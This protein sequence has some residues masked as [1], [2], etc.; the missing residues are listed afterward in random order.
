MAV[1]ISSSNAYGPYIALTNNLATY[2]RT[3]ELR[4]S[5]TSDTTAG[6]FE[7]INRSAP[8]VRMTVSELGAIRSNSH[9]DAK[10]ARFTPLSSV[11]LANGAE[12]TFTAYPGGLVCVIDVTGSTVGLFL[13]R[14]TGAAN[15]V[16]VS[17]NPAS[18]YSN[19]D[20][21]SRVC[22]YWN[23]T[24]YAVKNRTGATHD[25]SIIHL[26]ASNYA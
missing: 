4:S 7:V 14:G 10:S 13:V 22:L 5:G 11:N 21:A 17:E 1:Q 6:A 19:A 2:G 24:T 15:P 8:A 9:D 25:F 16:L 12:A 18:N 26:G 23:G 3:W 20:T